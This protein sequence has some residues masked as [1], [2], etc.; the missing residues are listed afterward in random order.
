MAF[1]ARRGELM[2]RMPGVWSLHVAP[3]NRS[4]NNALP[5]PF[6]VLVH[7][8]DRSVSFIHGRGPPWVE[9]LRS[10]ARC[11]FNTPRLI[12]VDIPRWKVG[13]LSKLDF[14]PS[15]LH[16]RRV[17]AY[18]I[19]DQDEN[20]TRKSLGVRRARKE[21]RK[22]LD[23]MVTGA[24][25]GGVKGLGRR[26]LSP[27]R[28]KIREAGVSH[29][30]TSSFPP[31][32]PKRRRQMECYAAPWRWTHR[33]TGIALSRSDS[34]N[35]IEK[36][37]FQLNSSGFSRRIFWNWIF[38]EKCTDSKWRI[39]LNLCWTLLDV[40]FRR[41]RFFDEIFSS[42]P[43]NIFLP[44]SRLFSFSRN[45]YSGRITLSW[46]VFPLLPVPKR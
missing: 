27:L 26:Q 19:A 7:W 14:T 31:P 32:P 43:R 36:E 25:A 35:I 9:Q 23:I 45:I 34:F 4:T 17:R 21:S 5:P 8:F 33:N 6:R 40:E 22:M 16:F 28:D 20:E 41:D 44:L 18:P 42:V 1:M 38:R 39:S 29:S 13:A 37:I 24:A 11:F 46:F 2:F 12:F 15:S 10:F 30:T 3:C